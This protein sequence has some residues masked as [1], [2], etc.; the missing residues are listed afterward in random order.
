MTLDGYPR[1]SVNTLGIQEK[2]DNGRAAAID[3]KRS[4]ML[5]TQGLKVDLENML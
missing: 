3:T 1:S 4:D 5:A 2:L